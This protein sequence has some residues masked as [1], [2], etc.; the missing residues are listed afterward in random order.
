MYCTSCQIYTN[1]LEFAAGD[2]EVSPQPTSCNKYVKVIKTT[3]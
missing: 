1:D 2:G 3:M